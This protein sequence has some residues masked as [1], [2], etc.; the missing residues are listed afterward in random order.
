MLFK[1]HFLKFISKHFIPFAASMN[2]IVNFI[3]GL[4]PGAYTLQI[5]T[6]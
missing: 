2:G 5:F 1:K 6:Y 3:F 4:F